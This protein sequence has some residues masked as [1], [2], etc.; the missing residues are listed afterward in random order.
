M[1]V[2]CKHGGNLCR[3]LWL[4]NHEIVGYPIFRQAQIWINVRRSSMQRPHL[5]ARSCMIA[6]IGAAWSSIHSAKPRVAKAS[7][8]SI[9]AANCR[10]VVSSFA[11]AGSTRTASSPWSSWAFHGGSS[12]VGKRVIK[13][14]IPVIGNNLVDSYERGSWMGKPPK[15]TKI[16]PFQ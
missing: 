15:K 5:Q 14:W 13:H 7:W 1:A 16:R 2:S 6:L 8:S 10:S 9:F 12:V 11:L 3:K 4:V